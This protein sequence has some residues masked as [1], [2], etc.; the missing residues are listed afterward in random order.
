MNGRRRLSRIEVMFL[1][2]ELDEFLRG[3]TVSNVYHL[4]PAEIL[5]LKINTKLGNQLLLIEP[6]FRVHITN[7]E[8]PI[9]ATPSALAKSWRKILRGSKILAVRQHGFD[10]VIVFELLSRGERLSLIVELIDGGVAAIV[11]EDCKVVSSTE[12]R[13]MKDRSISRGQPYVFPPSRFIDPMS[14]PDELLAEEMKSAGDIEKTISSKLG[15]GN[16]ARR[17]LLDSGVTPSGQLSGED[18]K[19]II[20]SIR[21]VFSSE[22][23]P[24]PIVVRHG[25]K[26]DFCI[27]PPGELEGFSASSFKYISEAI[28]VLHSE[29]VFPRKETKGKIASKIGKLE[30]LKSELESM[31]LRNKK[32]AD[33]IL[34]RLY[35]VDQAIEGA[36][37]G[38]GFTSD[39]GLVKV[40]DIK[41]G[42][43]TAIVSIDGEDVELDLREKA[44][45]N[46]TSKYELSKKLSRRLK[47]VEGELERLYKIPSKGEEVISLKQ[48]RR[49]EWFEK[50]RWGYLSSG[51]LI[52]GGKD[53]IT[54][55]IL[56]KRH[57]LPDSVVLHSDVAGAP[58]FTIISE[59]KPSDEEIQEAAQ[60]A[61]SYTTRAWNSNFSSLDVFW[62]YRN[63]LSKSPPS[64]EFL[65]RGAFVV[66]GA[67]NYIRGV[68]LTIAV[69]ITKEDGMAK[70]IVSTPKSISKVSDCHILVAPGKVKN[71]KIAEEIAKRFS[72]TLGLKAEPWL[73]EE[74]KSRLPGSRS[75]LKETQTS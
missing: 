13:V 57:T 25:G 55:E 41:W 27:K 32:H 11:D 17:I 3:G 50:F 33:L 21:A 37:H 49:K 36:R 30:R 42:S 60:L 51:E 46:A 12:Y 6:G 62:V 56:L 43:G 48:K 53:R 38:Y 18:I 22:F 34:K 63:Q 69:G 20:S 54:N 68:P 40:K 2:R 67:K 29:L 16:I 47:E 44:T 45:A 31:A 39:D 7:L 19:R 24:E 28:D 59:G 14:S 4:Q 64:G 74:I 70:V 35:D 73:I 52:I 23:K 15:L 71:S 65:E 9:P 26:V 58:F 8:Y 1:S 66:R 72:K 75:S 10:R 61:A 5:L